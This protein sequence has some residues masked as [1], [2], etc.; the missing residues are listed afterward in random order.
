LTGN[1]FTVYFMASPNHCK[2]YNTDRAGVEVK[3]IIIKPSTPITGTTPLAHKIYLPIDFKCSRT[4]R[5]LATR[6]SLDK[7]GPSIAL[8]SGLLR[9]ATD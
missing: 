6:S 3:E 9:R 2:H 7:L 8:I 1:F 4:L 5:M